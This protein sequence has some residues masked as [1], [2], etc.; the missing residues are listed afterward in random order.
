MTISA[1]YIGQSTVQVT[2]AFT[3]AGGTA[4]LTSFSAIADTIA[5]A[6]IGTQPGVA[7]T[8]ATME[9]LL[10]LLTVA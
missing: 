5:D 9:P 8:V 10:M 4:A 7:G 2:T 6:I 1:T 3:P